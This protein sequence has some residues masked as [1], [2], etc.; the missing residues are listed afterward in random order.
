MKIEIEFTAI[1]QQQPEIDEKVLVMTMFKN[2]I[3]TAYYKGNWTFDKL[4][5]QIVVT[6]EK[7]GLWKHTIT[8]P[9]W[10]VIDSLSVKSLPPEEYSQVKDPKIKIL[11]GGSYI[12]PLDQSKASFGLGGGINLN[13]KHTLGLNIATNKTLNINYLIRIR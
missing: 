9:E 13:N 1:N 5:L 4:P 11:V 6:E 12:Y 8:G 7:T 10:L 3:S 2:S